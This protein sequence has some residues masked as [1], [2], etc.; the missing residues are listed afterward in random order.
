MDTSCSF[1]QG[2]LEASASLVAR[3]V[4]LCGDTH[5][6]SARR[7]GGSWAV[8]KTVAPAGK[9]REDSRTHGPWPEANA[10][11]SAVVGRAG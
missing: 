5:R 6:L 4:D 10:A 9:A 3:P 2:P 1:P 7:V 8:R 11:V